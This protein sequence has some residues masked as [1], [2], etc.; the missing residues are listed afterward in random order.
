[1]LAGRQGRDRPIEMHASI[2]AAR[3]DSQRP[4]FEL[5]YKTLGIRGKVDEPPAELPGDFE[6]GG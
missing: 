6:A 5:R 1:V 2:V 4:L 3:T